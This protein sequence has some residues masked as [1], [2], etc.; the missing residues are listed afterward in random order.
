[1]RWVDSEPDGLTDTGVRE[2]R[3]SLQ[4][5]YYYLQSL[6]NCIISMSFQVLSECNYSSLTRYQTGVVTPSIPTF[7]I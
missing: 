1:M 6:S 4:S 5:G 2:G 3:H 7:G